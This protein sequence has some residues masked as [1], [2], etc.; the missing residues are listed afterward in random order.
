MDSKKDTQAR[1]APTQARSIARVEAI[2]SAAQH[3]LAARGVDHVSITDIAEASGMSKAAVYRYFPTKSA[4]VRQLADRMVTEDRAWLSRVLDPSSSNRRD[5][6]LS[7]LDAFGRKLMAD[8]YR[9]QLR[10]AVHAD[11]NLRAHGH[12]DMVSIAEMIARYLMGGTPEGEPHH[13]LSLRVL[14]VIDLLDG[15]I[16]LASR[17]EKQQQARV[18]ELYLEMAETQLGFNSGSASR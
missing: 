4:V 17:V 15:A 16:D 12:R 14:I 3:L 8:P 7:A 9:V 6:A 1:R 11:V 5:T 13:E 2:L 18:L 10:A